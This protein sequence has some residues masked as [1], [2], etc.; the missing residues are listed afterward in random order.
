[1][2]RFDR[3][4]RPFGALVRSTV[5][6]DQARR[7]HSTFD[8][9]N[10]VEKEGYPNPVRP[11]NLGALGACV[12]DTFVPETE[13]TPVA[14]NWSSNDAISDSESCFLNRVLIVRESVFTVRGRAVPR[15]CRSA[16]TWASCS[17]DA[18]G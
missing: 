9:I 10:H 2:A 3:Y 15:F 13:M 14:C 4:R 6:V 1:M 16:R 12:Y 11:F 5:R 18:I 17:S 8:S 7:S